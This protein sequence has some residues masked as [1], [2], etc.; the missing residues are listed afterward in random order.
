ME[1]WLLN[2][3]SEKSTPSVKPMTSGFWPKS[4]L[5]FR[6][7][8]NLTEQK[9]FSEMVGENEWD[10]PDSFVSHAA[11]AGGF[12]TLNILIKSSAI[13]FQWWR[14]PVTFPLFKL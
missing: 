5:F 7:S 11:F 12:H 2:C 10:Y 9:V 14:N 4:D 13:C 1:R 8:K 3:L 6:S